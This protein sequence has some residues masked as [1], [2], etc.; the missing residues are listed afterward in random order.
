MC[1]CNC[2]IPHIDVEITITTKN[3]K[4]RGVLIKDMKLH[5]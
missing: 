3:I 5:V 4:S 2:T 1:L